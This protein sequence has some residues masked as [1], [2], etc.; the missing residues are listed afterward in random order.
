[1]L[2]A[3]RG[4]VQQ[5]IDTGETTIGVGV[6]LEKGDIIPA[7]MLAECALTKPGWKQPI[8]SY[9]KKEDT[10]GQKLVKLEKKLR[11]ILDELNEEEDPFELN[12]SAG[13]KGD[14]H[15]TLEGAR[16]MW[17]AAVAQRTLIRIL[18]QPE[19][20]V[21]HQYILESLILSTMEQF[22][23]LKELTLIDNLTYQGPGLSKAKVKTIA[24]LRCSEMEKMAMVQKELELMARV[25][26]T[27]A[28]TQMA[29]SIGRGLR[30]SSRNQEFA[31]DSR[32]RGRG[33][34][35]YSASS[36][37]PPPAS[38]SSSSSSNPQQQGRQGGDDQ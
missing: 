33:K 19:G 10:K 23:V 4:Q 34:G 36:S 22:R 21:R 31:S 14:T 13:T 18:L 7:D 11:D 20:H 16:M 35:K 38:S 17:K 29:M 9:I 25:Q 6:W 26:N 32:G 5:A 24:N 37:A 1:V 2:N 27:Q 8:S 12:P 3:V 28:T 30:Q 15:T